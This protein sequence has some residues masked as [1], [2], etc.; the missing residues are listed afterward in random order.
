MNLFAYGE[1][2]NDEVLLKL[3]NRIPSR[4]KGKIKGYEK[5]FDNS[6][7][8]Y[9]I[10]RKEGSEVSGIILLE[11]SNE[12]LKRFDEFEDEGEYYHRVKTKAYTDTGEEYEVFI[13]LREM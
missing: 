3:I 13:Y 8:Y 11:I 9:G 4:K 5:F 10:R 6:I 2:M 7:G 12:E 1:L